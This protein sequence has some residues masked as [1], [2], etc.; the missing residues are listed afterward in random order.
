MCHP[1]YLC[2]ANL[3]ERQPPIFIDILRAS[4]VLY[5]AKDILC[6]VESEKRNVMAFYA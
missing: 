2:L 6:T 3:Y 4:Q 5:I 1:A